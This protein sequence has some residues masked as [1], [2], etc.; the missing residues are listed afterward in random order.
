MALTMKYGGIAR[1]ELRAAAR[2]AS[3]AGVL[4]HRV[5]RL[6][7]MREAQDIGVER[8]QGMPATY[9]PGR[10][11]VFYSVAWSWAEE[12]GADYIVGGH[13]RD[14]RGVFR[15]VSDGFFRSM[16]AAL[17]EGSSAL[18]ERRTRILRPLREKTKAEV[19]GL[20]VRL[21]VPLELTWSCHRDGKLHC[22]DCDGCRARAS[23]FAKAGVGDPLSPGLAGRLWKDS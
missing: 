6:P 1:S 3:A 20:A 9:I 21:G 10:N 18:S 14:D 13:N 12:A 4:E 22:W 2:I 7:D 17:W 8:F 23:A 16:Q 15:D 19:I 5:V 11:A